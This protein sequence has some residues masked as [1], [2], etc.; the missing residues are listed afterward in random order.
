VVRAEE[1]L[2]LAQKERERESK[3]LTKDMHRYMEEV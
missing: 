2:K 3:K 1:A